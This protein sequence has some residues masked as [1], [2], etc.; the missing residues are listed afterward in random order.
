MNATPALGYAPGLSLAPQAIEHQASPTAASFGSNNPFRNRALSPGSISSNNRPER[1][2]STNP[3]LDDTEAMSPQ[4]APGMSTGVSMISPIEK[5]NMSSNTRELFESLS[6]NPA[7]QPDRPRPVA[8]D[9]T[10]RTAS[11]RN[12]PPRDR[13]ER[14][15]GR[16]AESKER[17]PLDIFADPPTSSQTAKDKAP[18]RAR[19]NSESSVMDR[20]SKLLDLDD[21]DK[22]RRERRREREGR[23]KDVKSRS[24]R[25]DRRLDII[26]KLDVTSIYGTGM[27]HHDGP[28]DAC[29]PHRNRRGVRTAPMQAFPK[30]ST[31]MAL[32]GSGPNNSNIDL[33]LFHGRMEEGH[34]DFST[35]ARR[36]AETGV[37]DPTAR[38]DPIHGPQT[39]GLGTSTFLDG[40]PASRSA[41]ARRQ[42]E[43]ENNPE[44]NGG[45]SRKKSLAQRLRGRAAG[46]GRISSPPDNFSPAPPQVS[47][48]HSTS[49]R[50]NE[51]NP[52]FEEEEYEEEWDKKG[53]SIEARLG[54]GRL[55][56]S[57]SP[58]QTTV[59][60]RKITNDRPYEESKLNPGSGGFLNRMKSLRKPKPE[61][62][63]SD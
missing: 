60:E 4:S 35:A 28:F 3:F 5:N 34:N 26:D 21:D 9:A 11:N 19:R 58:K 8:S 42:S 45:L 51:R 50:A 12:R 29:N 2:R 53:S 17:D 23:S 15:P 62:R 41:M 47:S 16:S 22:R 27:F 46:P 59:L 6:L 32:G 57:S 54:G 38:V 48:S 13:S 30:G 61:R 20:S 25:K 18:R 36:N 7:P 31:N 56:S 10:Q 40:A 1:P 24:G 55:R 37:V 52:Y 44:P 39:M 33:N 43:N 63:T 14:P 49:A